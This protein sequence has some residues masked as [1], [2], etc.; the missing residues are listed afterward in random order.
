MSSVSAPSNLQQVLGFSRHREW[1][2]TSVLPLFGTFFL[3]AIGNP[4]GVTGAII[5]AWCAIFLLGTACGYML[6]NLSDIEVDRRAG[7]R[8]FLDHWTFAGRLA[9][10]VLLEAASLGLTLLLSDAWTLAAIGVCHL[11]V[12]SY[13]FPPRFK[14]HIV[15]GPVV[16]STQFWAPSA[17]ILIAWRAASPAAFCWTLILLVYGLRLTLIHQSL[18]RQADLVTG[19]R[20]TAVSLSEPSLRRLLAGLFSMEVLLV[21]ALLLLGF[22]TGLVA[23][24]TIPL[25][26]LAPLNMAFRKLRGQ[27]IRLDTY[28]YVPLSEL[29]ETVIPLSFA[30]TGWWR[31]NIAWGPLAMF[32][33]L[34]LARHSG[35]FRALLPSA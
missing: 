25:V 19:V 21:G 26:L 24:L 5:L 32:G 7:K 33:L 10:A 13:S 35:R 16:A 22:L 28:D 23:A 3:A 27:R 18:D 15:M 11:I 29:Y 1:L 9:I 14:E 8:T 31:G 30:V 12:W 20:T 34:L 4:H 2:L 17:V 6:N